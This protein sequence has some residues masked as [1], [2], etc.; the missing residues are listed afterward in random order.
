MPMLETLMQAGMT[1]QE[2][3]RAVRN[4]ITPAMIENLRWMQQHR[5]D[6]LARY[7]AEWERAGCTPP[8]ADLLDG[9]SS[10]GTAPAGTDANDST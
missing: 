2:A 6:Q 7:A 8:W 9:W 5:P 1:V 10:P 4:Q 3:Y